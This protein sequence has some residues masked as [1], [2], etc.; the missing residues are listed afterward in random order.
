MTRF[1]HIDYPTTHPGVQRLEAAFHAV[2]QALA[3]FSNWRGPAKLLLLAAC[4]VLMV[5]AFQVSGH[6][7]DGHLLVLWTALWV[8]GFVVLALFADTARRLTLRLKAGLDDW[9]RALAE[10]KADERLWKLARSDAR[11]MAD[12]QAAAARAESASSAPAQAAV[13]RKAAT[14]SQRLQWPA[15]QAPNT[16]AN[17]KQAQTLSLRAVKPLAYYF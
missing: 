14:L 15:A 17:S 12:L 6:V 4:M 1:V 13:D 3:G 7:A 5:T 16:Q 8:A 2:Q 9:S 11:V 10:A